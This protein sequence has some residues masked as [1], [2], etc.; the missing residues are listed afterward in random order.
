MCKSWGS[1]EPRAVC[2]DS[3]KKVLLSEPID[4]AGIKV[5]EGRVQLLVSPDPSERSVG[6][7]MKDVH[8]LIVRTATRINRAMIEAAANLEVISRTGGGLDNVDVQAATDHRIVVC[9]VKGP[10][11][12]FVAEHAVSL[13]TALAKQ[14][15]YLNGE[16]R[17]GNFKARFEYRPVGLAG[18]RVGLVGLGRIG[19][20]VAETCIRGLGMEVLGFDPYI[21]AEDIKIPGLLVTQSLQEVIQTADFLSLHVPLS[22]ETRGLIGREHLR[23]MKPTAFLI[24]TSRGEIIEEPAL[25]S[26]LREGTIAGAALDVFAKEPPDPR[27]PL[28]Q[29]EN[30]ILTPHTA[31]LTRDAVARLAEGAAQ[32]VID[33]LEGREPSYS[34]NWEEVKS[35]C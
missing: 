22:D 14:L 15:F 21:K 35:G 3:V 31:S 28:F 33:V 1:Y 17:R 32:N 29:L 27:H 30:V 20:L 10:Q 16:V 24:N 7:M 13:M 6:Q 11:D 19:R 12:R 9:G 5:L 26:A 25:V 4:R 23:L 2:E 34:V 18:K 8:G